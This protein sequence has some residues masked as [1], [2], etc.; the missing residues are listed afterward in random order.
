[1]P[2]ISVVVATYNYLASL[3]LCIAS[4]ERQ[5]FAP[6]EVIIADD[7]SGEDVVRWLREYS[8]PLRI[9]HIWQEDQGFRKC[10]ILNKAIL[11]AE[12][13]YLVFIDADCIQAED[14]LQVHWHHKE[15]NK[16]LGGRR[17]MMSRSL[18]EELASK[19]QNIVK[20]F[21]RIRVWMLIEVLR[22]RIRYLEEALQ[23]LYRVRGQKS[24]SL[25]GCNFSIHKSSL[26]SVNGFDED[27]ETRGGGEDTDIAARLDLFGVRMKSV[28]YLARQFHLG[29]DKSEDK[30]MS[31]KMFFVKKGRL[32]SKKDATEINSL[33][34]RMKR[35]EKKD[36]N[37]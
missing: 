12:A 27:Y 13:E 36:S 26:L 1:M 14:F 18:A 34:A 17:V 2:N 23:L 20:R 15:E 7:G 19:D 16:F 31:E 22:G 33:I 6:F 11:A 10:K 28:R 35:N 24:F 37:A 9:K 8:G 30:S 29:H 21:N 4:L 25:L 32:T 5:T 3:K